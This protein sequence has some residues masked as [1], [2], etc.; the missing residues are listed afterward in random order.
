VSDRLFTRDELNALTQ[1]PAAQFA[2]AVRESHGNVEQVLTTFDRLERSYRNFVDGFD[3]FAAALHEWTLTNHG[4]D[5]LTALLR[6]ERVTTS[7]DAARRGLE[8]DDVEAV[9]T[10]GRFREPLRERLSAGDN[11]GA[12]ELFARMEDSMRRVHDNACVRAVAALSHVYR[13]YGVA[14]LEASIRLAGER[15]LLN[16]MPH[17]LSRGPAD[18]VKRWSRMM[19]GNFAVITIEEHDD[20][21]VITQDPCG[22]CTRQVIDHCYEPPVDLAVVSERCP[23]TFGQGDMP[24]YRTHVAVMHY[25]QGIERSGVPWPAIECPAGVTAGPCRISLYKNPAATPP[26]WAA[27]I[28]Q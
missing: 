24:V 5:A 22:T 8:A 19:L 11:A 7:I 15:T 28:A 6:A 18:R 9:I 2:A 12:L 10:P 20:R 26:E 17:D 1:L 27:R 16:F 25:L 23:L 21:F 13:T 3:A 4:F 14:G